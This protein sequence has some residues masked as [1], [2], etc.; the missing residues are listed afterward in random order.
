[1]KWLRTIS[2]EILGL[3]VDDASFAVAIIAWLVVVRFISRH[4]GPRSV[5]SAVT[6]AVGLVLILIESAVRFAKRRVRSRQEQAV[7]KRQP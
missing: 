7:G 1:M 5:W 2:S 6:L 4:V 3:F